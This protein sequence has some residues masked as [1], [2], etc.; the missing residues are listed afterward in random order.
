MTTLLESSFHFGMLLTFLFLVALI[1][2]GM[3]VSTG[4]REPLWGAAVAIGLL[5]ALWIVERLV[6]T[7]REAVEATLY[8]IAADVESNNRAAILAHIHSGAPS[9]KARAEAE[10]P[11][12]TFTQC[13]INKLHRID[14]NA[15]AEPPSA[16]AEFNVFVSGSFKVGNETFVG[17]L[18]R[19]I[20]L[21]LRK[22]GDG[23]WRV[24]NYAHADPLRGF[25]GG[26]LLGDPH[27]GE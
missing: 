23:V 12:Y 16:V 26:G 14:V 22:D 18:P 11:N 15:D 10:M 20:A 19:Y 3:W 9:L 13:T 7:E 4:R 27:E 5:P 24:E 8:Q 1:L 2:A 21:E 17:E 25:R 6:V